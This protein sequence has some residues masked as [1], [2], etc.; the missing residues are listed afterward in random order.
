M[1]Y[2]WIENPHIKQDICEEV[3]KDLP[4]WFGIPS[5]LKAYVKGV[6]N[7]PFLAVYDTRG[8]TVGFYALREENAHTLDMYV[9]GI[10]K[11]Y[12][13][14]GV[15]RRLQNM[16]EQFAREKGYHQLIVLTLS[17]KA[18]SDAYRQTRAFYNRMGFKALY[19]SDAIWGEKNPCSILVKHIDE[20]SMK[21]GPAL[22][23]ETQRL[24]IR[25]YRKEDLEAFHEI[26][27]DEE[28]MDLC[29]E[30]YSKTKSERVLRHFMDTMIAYAVE[31]KKE[32]R[33]IGHLLFKQVPSCDEGVFEIGWIFNKRHWNKGFAYEAAFAALEYGFE[34]LGVH[35]VIAE[36]ID[37][38]KSLSLMKKLG[39][40]HEGT[41]RQQ[42]FH[43]GRWN[44]LY[45][46][47]ILCSEFPSQ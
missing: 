12:Q 4:E 36:T 30:T 10:K 13:G 46:A 44:D 7:K 2:R 43:A 28:V 26:F 20:R 24:Y 27:S 23:L 38:V 47:G 41:M 31:H 6:S 8:E 42:T 1:R 37:P 35:K 39:M 9:L 25:P 32:G 14:Q 5:A 33:M 16:V 21:K 34:T 11:A 40:T 19:Q 15:G 18:N 3:L 22:F 45:M 29:E 17:E